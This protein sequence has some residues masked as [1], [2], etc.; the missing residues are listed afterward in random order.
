MS[1]NP[2]EK[3][4]ELAGTNEVGSL[5]LFQPSTDRPRP[6]VKLVQLPDESLPPME[7][8]ENEQDCAACN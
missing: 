6:A 5:S 2:T 3:N 1:V 7:E 4:K 8:I